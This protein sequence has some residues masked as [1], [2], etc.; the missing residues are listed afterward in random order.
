MYVGVLLHVALLVEALATIVA[1]IRPRV[2]VDE[3]VGGQSAGALESL[4]ALLA[5]EH[6]LH[7]VHR[8]GI[9]WRVVGQISKGPGERASA[10]IKA[11]LKSPRGTMF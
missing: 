5:L 3:Q 2:A 1:W 11:G 6:L 7:V 8:P 9:I 4:A 10:L